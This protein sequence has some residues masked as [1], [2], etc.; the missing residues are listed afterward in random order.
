VP[1]SSSTPSTTPPSS[2][3]ARSSISQENSDLIDLEALTFTETPASSVCSDTPERIDP[4]LLCQR[5][6][7]S[8][9]EGAAFDYEAIDVVYLTRPNKGHSHL[10]IQ[11]GSAQDA[12]SSQ[13]TYITNISNNHL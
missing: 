1:S 7:P 2:R 4:Q 6:V 10:S 11:R 9:T 13:S 5:V 3:S 12:N 8:I